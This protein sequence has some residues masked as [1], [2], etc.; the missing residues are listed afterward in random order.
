VLVGTTVPGADRALRRAVRAVRAAG[1]AAPILVGGAGIS[2]DT[3][4]RAL[5]ATGWSGADAEAAMRTVDALSRPDAAT[6]P[7][8]R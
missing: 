6:P 7:A 5:G 8:R 1:V 3:H 2:G 4:A